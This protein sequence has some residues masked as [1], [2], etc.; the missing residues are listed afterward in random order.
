[1][2]QSSV[3]L[4]YCCDYHRMYVRHYIVGWFC[5]PN[6]HDRMRKIKTKPTSLVFPISKAILKCI[7]IH[8]TVRPY[9]CLF[10]NLSNLQS[11]IALLPYTFL[12]VN[13]IHSKMQTTM[14]NTATCKQMHADS[15][16]S[17]YTMCKCPQLCT[18]MSIA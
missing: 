6:K 14:A 16:M 8:P 12:H 4:V 3:G 1:M 13:Q 2:Y 17:L 5:R 15:S 10:A 7:T 11:E 9:A 18:I